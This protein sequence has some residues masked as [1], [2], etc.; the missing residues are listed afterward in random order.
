M[1]T[2]PCAPA[3]NEPVPCRFLS[4]FQI[5]ITF[6]LQFRLF[7]VVLE[8]A[9]RLAV[10]WPARTGDPWRRGCSPGIRAAGA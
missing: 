7:P 8:D 6:A 1:V 10:S 9:T 4:G 2:P 3:E 5:C